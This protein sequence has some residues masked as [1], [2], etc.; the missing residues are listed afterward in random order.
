M[1]SSNKLNVETQYWGHAEVCQFFVE[2][3]WTL[4]KNHIGEIDT[5]E[6]VYCNC[7][8]SSRISKCIGKEI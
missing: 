5:V 8:E 6:G 7:K 3:N 2:K 1:F 4:E